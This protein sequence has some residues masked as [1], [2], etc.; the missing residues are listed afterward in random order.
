MQFEVS[1]Q[2]DGERLDKVLSARLPDT[3]RS[4]L[5]DLIE[6]DGVLIDGNLVTKPKQKL[7]L[8]QV[9]ELELKPRPEDASFTPTE[10]SLD[11]VYE[12]NSLIVI[13]KPIGLVVHPAVGHWTDTL[14]NGLLAYSPELSNLPRAGIVHRI[15]KDTSGLMVVAKTEQAQVNLANQL[16][17]RTVK[18]EYWALARGLAPIEKIID[19]PIERDPRNA[20]RFITSKA[21]RARPALT[22][23]KLV[24]CTELKGKKYSWV[25]VRLHTGRTHQ[26]RVHMESIGLPL[27]GDP[28]Y[29]NRLPAPKDDGTLVSTF[30]RQALHACRL[31]LVHPKTGQV[32]QWFVEPPEDLRNLMD[33]LGFKPW[34]QPTTAFADPIVSVENPN[35]DFESVSN[36]V[37]CISSWDD[38][39]FGEDD[40]TDS[41]AQEVEK[42]KE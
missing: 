41:S 22:K 31:G 1:L 17:K 20:L 37:G 36:K 6:E 27:I 12:D 10:M 30:S 9:V 13:N 24:Q 19:A 18:R 29:R 14:V 21:A 15:D 33:E 42:P 2:E 39:D 25:A 8:G 32:M 4:R 23:I 5:K 28:L 38:F 34:D 35:K 7:V 3:S 26:I 16:Q 40:D 11:I